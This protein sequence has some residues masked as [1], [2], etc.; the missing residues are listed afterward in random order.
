MVMESFQIGLKCAMEEIKQESDEDGALISSC[1]ILAKKYILFPTNCRRDLK[2]FKDIIET[3]RKWKYRKKTAK[4]QQA[5]L[6]PAP[7]IKTCFLINKQKFVNVVAKCI[8]EEMSNMPTE[9]VNEKSA[10]KDTLIPDDMN[11]E[12]YLSAEDI[13]PTCYE[14]TKED[15][16]QSLKNSKDE[17]DES[18]EDEKAVVADDTHNVT[19]SKPIK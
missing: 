10:K 13:V 4:F 16:I 6:N 12:A 7:K 1:L 17:A 5:K 2:S 14:L 3:E 19:S 9:S 8:Y 18:S 15:I 11:V